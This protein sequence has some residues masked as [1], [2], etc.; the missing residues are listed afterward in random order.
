MA[1][2]VVPIKAREIVH[3]MIAL[4]PANQ[5]LTVVRVK[6]MVRVF[7]DHMGQPTWYDRAYSEGGW[8][9]LISQ[10]IRQWESGE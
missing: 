8:D 7:L 9:S 10:C 6:A 2:D 5:P 1:V 4:T 3:Q